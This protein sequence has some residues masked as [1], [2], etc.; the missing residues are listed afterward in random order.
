MSDT[1]TF[2]FKNYYTRDIP[3]DDGYDGAAVAAG[4]TFPVRIRRFSVAQL[5]AF[6]RGFARLMNPTS[7]RFIYRKPDGDEQEMREIPARVNDKGVQIAAAR[8]AHVIP[9]AEI[10]RRRLAEMDVD[11]RAKYDAA[12]E[13]DDEFM[14]TFCGAA[15]REHVWLPPGVRFSVVQDD[16]SVAAVEGGK[17]SG[18]GLVQVFGG[19]L[20]MLVRLTKA[21]HAENTLSPEAKKA[22]RLLSDL[23]ASLSAPKADGPTPAAIV[24]PAEATGSAPNGDASTGLGPILSGS[25]Q[26]ATSS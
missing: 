4:E 1:K 24:A 16:D 11:T 7:E 14:T 25:T 21:I 17:D 26:A 12:R 23:M 2:T 10:E 18:H 13:A 6:Q 19:N 20:S 8:T 15:I 5:Q 3:I 9:D 22:S